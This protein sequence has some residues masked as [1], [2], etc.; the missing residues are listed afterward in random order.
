[1]DELLFDKQGKPYL[2][3]VDTIIKYLNFKLYKWLKSK[4]RKAHKQF[5]QRPYQNMVKYSGL[6]DLSK[7]A[8]LKTLAKAQ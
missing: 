6:L 5:R 2:E 3:T 4:G 7:Y 1:M 8:R